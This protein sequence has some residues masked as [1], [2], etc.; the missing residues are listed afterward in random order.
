MLMSRRHVFSPVASAGAGAALGLS[1]PC[2][3]A[4]GS[5]QPPV[6][7]RH[8]YQGRPPALCVCD[9]AFRPLPNGDWGIL[10]MTGGDGEPRVANYIALCRSTDRGERWTSPETVLRYDDEACL[11]T[12]AY[13][14][15]GHILVHGVRHGGRFENWRNFTISSGDSGQTWSEPAPF[16]PMPRRTFIR[17]LYR[18]TWGEWY[19]PYQTYD[20]VEEPSVSPLSDG[21]HKAALNGVLISQDEGKTWSR[22]EDTGP[23]PGWAENNIVETRDGRL[24]MLI[25]AD[26]KGHL[27][28]SESAG[29][30]RTW[31]PPKPTD[32]PNPG[33][34]FR[35]FR[36][37][38]GRVLL[39]HNPSSTPGL[40]NPLAL[41]ASDDDMA[42]WPVKRLIT[43]FP[44][45]LQYPDG[46]VSD[47]ETCVRFAFDYN[48]HDLVFGEARVPA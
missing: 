8:V 47:D 5:V 11:L 4:P 30:G 48:R 2:S 15:A 12:E 18:S 36:L 43:D 32:I 25:R 26:G 41:W 22:S 33:S 1:A 34:K 14:H 38:N 40:R 31:T 29:R 3:A 6:R 35:L 42:S 45:K 23:V 37:E 10:F 13:V 24:V 28:R 9:Q 19:L 39:L 44:G 20:T 7:L 27:L 21:S 16:E 17:N 46:V